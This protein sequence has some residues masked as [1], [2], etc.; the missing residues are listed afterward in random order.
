M[1]HPLSPQVSS[2]PLSSPPPPPRRLKKSGR[3][4][5]QERPAAA[6]AAGETPM[7]ERT[8]KKKEKTSVFLYFLQAKALLCPFLSLLCPLSSLRVLLSDRDERRRLTVRRAPL[9]PSNGRFLSL[10]AEGKARDAAFLSLLL[11]SPSLSPSPS[12]SPPFP[13]AAHLDLNVANLGLAAQHGAA[14][15]RGEDVGGEVGAG[16][17]ALDKTRAVVAHDHGVS[18]VILC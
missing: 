5:K 3:C 6:N 15:E 17:A 11:F 2:P 14:D 10:T 8:Q 7:R 4:T 13:P 9:S 1:A 16:V 18:P 12:P